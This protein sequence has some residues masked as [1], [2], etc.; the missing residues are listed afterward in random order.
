MR[1][2]WLL[3]PAVALFALPAVAQYADNTPAFGIVRPPGLVHMLDIELAGDRA[4]VVGTGGLWIVDVKNPA[5]PSLL[6]TYVTTGGEGRGGPQIYGAAMNGN[7]VYCFERTNGVEIIDVTD[8]GRPTSVGARYLRDNSYS[9]EHGVVS[10]NL[11]Y[12]AAH[13]HGVE[14]LD[15]SNPR[16]LIHR[17]VVQTG[18]AFDL[19]INGDYLFVADGAAGLSVVDVSDPLAPKLLA[20]KPTSNLAQDIVLDDQY[21]FVAVGSSGMDVFDINTPAAPKFVTNYYV[22]GFT[23]HLNI[24]NGRAFLANWETVEIVDI[25]NPAQPDLVATQHAFQR[26]MAI[27]TAGD[28]FYVGDWSALRPYRFDNIPAPDVNADPLEMNFGTVAVGGAQVQNLTIENLG[29]APL[30]ISSISAT[31]AGFSVASATFTLNRFERREIPVTYR[32]TSTNRVS[33]FINIVSNDPDEGQKIV[34]LTG[35]NNTIGVGDAPPDFTL[36]DL[37]GASYHLLDFIGQR[38]IIVLAFYASW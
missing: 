31:G 5:S 11:L 22:D 18:N 24:S 13:D 19:A 37:K 1:R 10:G 34:P 27:A 17:A 38:K 9:Y 15:V 23:N 28:Y 32:P 6:G 7:V 4:Y 8:P 29:K 25:S 3:F 33:G 2:N 30:V 21:A 20:T 12:L 36:Q 35:G 14:I 16:M 26:A